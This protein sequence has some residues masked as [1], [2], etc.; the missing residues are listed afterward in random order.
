M[1]GAEGPASEP[2]QEGS[3]KMAPQPSQKRPATSTQAAGLDAIGA[4]VEQI[5]LQWTLIPQYEI[6]SLD[7]A[8]RV[9]VRDSHHA[10]AFA[11]KEHAERYAIQMKQSVFPPGVVTKDGWLVDGA[12]RTAGCIINGTPHFPFVELDVEWEKAPERTRREIRVLA[13]T[14]NC[15]N[16]LPMTAQERRAAIDDMLALNFRQEQIARRLGVTTSTVTA[17]K[18]EAEA[19]TRLAA[20]EVDG[21]GIKPAALRALGTRDVLALNDA[22]YRE[23]A[24]LA[25][26][27]GMKSAEIAETARTAR[28]AGSDDGALEVISNVRSALSDRIR[29][30]ALTGKASASP[31]PQSRQMRLHLGFINARAGQEQALAETDPAHVDDYVAMLDKAIAVLNKV[32]YIQPVER[33]GSGPGGGSLW[34]KPAYLQTGNQE[35]GEPA[36][37]PPAD[38]PSSRGRPTLSMKKGAGKPGQQS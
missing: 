17:A 37:A 8:K 30:K 24:D 4:E 14:L 25:S 3:K 36:P 15:A 27:A 6:G 33:P 38:P 21:S 19:K 10:D 11:P 16:G 18:R 35:G 26:Q 22:P 29:Q 13:E 31:A 5:G 28:V 20:A 12:T 7:L 9:Q 32:R 34:Q 2:A 1:A 23:L